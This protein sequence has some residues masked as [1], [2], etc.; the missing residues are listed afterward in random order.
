MKLSNKLF[1]LF[2]LVLV[3]FSMQV[4]SNHVVSAAV[5][6][7]T[8]SLN[9]P[10]AFKNTVFDAAGLTWVFYED[11]PNWGYKATADAGNWTGSGFTSVGQAV[12]NG[13]DVSYNGTYLS[14]VRMDP[15]T[16]DTFYRRGLPRSNGSFLWS[17]PEQ[18]VWDAVL[19]SDYYTSLG[20]EVD[21]LGYAWI[22]AINRNGDDYFPAVLKNNVTDGT[23][24]L[25]FRTQLNT[26]P[27][28]GYAVE[29]VPL[30]GGAMYVI[31]GDVGEP[32]LGKFWNN[33]WGPEEDDLGDY[34]LASR[35]TFTATAIED[36]VHVGYMAELSGGKL[37]TNVRVNE[38]GWNDNDTEVRE[39]G[40]AGYPALLT[41]DTVTG[42]V[43][44]FYGFNHTILYRIYAS[45][46]WGDE[47]LFVDLAPDAFRNGE[48][49]NVYDRNFNGSIGIT[50]QT[51]SPSPWDINFE[52]IV[53]LEV[54][55]PGGAG[56]PYND[57][58]LILNH[59]PGGYLQKDTWYE[60]AATGGDT[61]GP[62]FV[63]QI[64]YIFD[65]N[66]LWVTFSWD[67][68]TNQ[69]TVDRPDL[70]HISHDHQYSGATS[71]PN[72]KV[73]VCRFLLTSL[74]D[75]SDG[76]DVSQRTQ[77][78]NEEWAPWAKVQA[79]YFMVGTPPVEQGPA[80]GSVPPSSSDPD[81]PPPLDPNDPFT[82][83][84]TDGDG[85]PD[86]EDTDIDG[87]GIPNE[88]D[89][90]SNNDGVLD[91]DEIDTDGDGTPDYSDPDDDGDGIPDI[92]DRDDD[93]DDIPDEDEKDTDGDGIRD[94]WDGDIDGDG[95]PNSEDPDPFHA[96]V[97]L[98]PTVALTWIQENGYLILLGLIGIVV[99]LSVTTKKA[100]QDALAAVDPANIV[101]MAPNGDY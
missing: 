73:A 95:I 29:L 6:G 98:R 13:W 44:C 88:D 50:Y 76:V 24:E 55:G 42:D 37:F 96:P 89:L 48:F 15:G 60:A 16:G 49:M 74:M 35:F 94:D 33:T 18:L 51:G 52:P 1:G 86:S 62:E 82:E 11:G 22:G 20:I 77:N 67:K 101:F 97:I 41:A 54:A 40:D 32:L 12:N 64:E 30:T 81:T 28:G 10:Y 91:V 34:D 58:F 90:D 31:W 87:D 47:V 78:T 70:V 25:D 9:G 27:S 46:V 84:D 99:F 57:G 92:S 85:I 68:T 72:I 79:N 65:V 23:W 43:Y 71:D 3:I 66:G 100:R 80:G 53:G 5:V 8:T 93:G 4:V 21:S 63:N 45:G 39:S 83:P 7:P 56:T 61:G 17:A 2:S 59:D 36:D 75:D 38:V 14:Y 19:V 26:T 69:F